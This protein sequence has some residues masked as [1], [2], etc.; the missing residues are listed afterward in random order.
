MVGRP[1]DLVQVAGGH[2]SSGRAS[3]LCA[4]CGTCRAMRYAWTIN[5]P[6]SVISCGHARSERASLWWA[7]CGTCHTMREL[8]TRLGRG[9]WGTLARPGSCPDENSVRLGDQYVALV[10]GS[11]FRKR[12]CP[13]KRR[14]QTDLPCQYL[15]FRTA[16][17]GSYSRVEPSATGPAASGP[18]LFENLREHRASLQIN[19]CAALGRVDPRGGAGAVLS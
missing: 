8:E 1:F 18:R 13:G 5:S 3:R 17:A 7:P 10:V 11:I 6:G 12:N 9:S 4:P 16:T 15:E 14:G 19:T 2:A